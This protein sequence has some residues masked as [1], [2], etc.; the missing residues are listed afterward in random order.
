MSEMTGDLPVT[1]AERLHDALIAFSTCV[2]LAVPD[3]CSFGVTI[4]ESYVPFNPDPED[5][6][7]EEEVACSQLWV[8]VESVSENPGIPGGWDGDCAA[9]LSLEIEVG[10]LRC[11]DV[12]EEGEAP[13]ASEMLLASMQAMSDMTAIRCA[14][15]SCDAWSGPVVPGPWRPLGPLGGQ[16]GGL[17]MFTVE[18][19]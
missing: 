10:V 16:Y 13:V 5:D 6:C 7:E 2:G 1:A 9:T 12:P 11:L 14:A 8:R 19:D 17:W 15:V 3:I 4:G 18:I